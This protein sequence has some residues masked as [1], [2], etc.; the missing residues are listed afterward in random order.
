M[1]FYFDGFI[2]VIEKAYEILYENSNNQNYEF[3]TFLDNSKI[4]VLLTRNLS[5][6]FYKSEALEA[7]SKYEYFYYDIKKWLL[8]KNSNYIDFKYKNPIRF[9]FDYQDG[10]IKNL[11]QTSKKLFGDDD[12]LISGK[13]FGEQKRFEDFWM[14]AVEANESISIK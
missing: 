8:E 3:K 7:I 12:L 11:I 2:D 4:W 6:A 13:I 10:K 5:E 1:L 14:E 9:K